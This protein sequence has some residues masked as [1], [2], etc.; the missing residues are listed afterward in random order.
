MTSTPSAARIVAPLYR[1]R[2]SLLESEPEI[3]RLIELSSALRLDEV[4]E[5]LQGAMGWQNAHLHAFSNQH[6][7]GRPSPASTA[8][9]RRDWV[10]ARSLEEGLDGEDESTATLGEVLTEQSGPL[11]YNYDFGDDWLHT[12]E[13]IEVIENPDAAEPL[14]AVIRGERA[15]PLE[16]SGGVH[17]YADKLEVLTDPSD[18]RFEWLSEWVA[19]MRSPWAP[20]SGEPF[21]PARFDVAAANAVLVEWATDRESRTGT[22]GAPVASAH[23]VLEEV[24]Q[25][26][27]PEAQRDLRGFLRR[28]GAEAEPEISAAEAAAMVAPYLWLLR[29]V[30]VDGLPLT[31][32]GWL[33]PAVVREAMQELGWADGWL[34]MMNREENTQP[35]F[36][37]RRSAQQYGL[38]RK[39]KG[40]LVL[41]AAAKKLLENPRGLWDYLAVAVVR[42]QEDEA[43]RDAILFLAAELATGV[44][45]SEKEM[46][47]AIFFGLEGAGWRFDARVSP[48]LEVLDLVRDGRQTLRTLGVVET[49]RT[50]TSD[51][52]RASPGGRE[53][54]RA[55]LRA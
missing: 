40:R 33:P 3:W 25:N 8:A 9:D 6:P 18:E 13:L 44:R 30:G 12:L 37:L 45:S 16:D 41:G 27:P 10:D 24:M 53:F 23:G 39:L 26:L 36:W 52:V 4:H 20:G 38:L 34:G 1:V 32:A 15:C 29:R 43:S 7:Y 17:G 11:F 31:P 42:R 35:V 48:S 28:N 14:A 49:E 55:M 51:T 54:A 47:F 21:D 50:I 22:S 46:F 5:V 2:L 19:G